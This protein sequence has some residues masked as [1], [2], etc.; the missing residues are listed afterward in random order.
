MDEPA[1]Y[2]ALIAALLRPEAYPHPVTAISVMETHI[3][4]VLLTGRHAYKLKKPVRLSFLDFSTLER[5]HAACEKELGLNRRFAPALYEAVVPITGSLAQPRI[6]G[7]GAAL[8]FAVRMRQFPPADQLDLRLNRGLLK[9]DEFEAFGHLMARLH[10]EAATA[11]D[12]DQYG[13]PA[14][15]HAPVHDSLRE[16]STDFPDPDSRRRLQ[17]LGDWCRA[18]ESAHAILFAERRQTGRIREGHG[19]LHLA[20]LVWLDGAILPFDCIE[21]SDDL[22]W[23]DVISDAAF[24]VMDLLHRQQ[25]ALAYGF[26][27]A[28]LE[29]SGDYAGLP[30]L[31]YYLVYRALVRAKVEGIRARAL[32]GESRATHLRQARDYLD[33]AATIAF[34]RHPGLVLMHGLSGSG[35]SWISQQ[36]AAALPAIRLRSDVE[37]KRLHGLERQARTGS[38]VAGGLYSAGA[39]EDT[40]RRLQVLAQAALDGGEHVIVDACFLKAAQRRDFLALAQRMG[41]PCRILHCEAAPSVL[42]SRLAARARE[43]LDPSEADA[44]VLA[45]QQTSAEPLTG[46]DLAVTV[47]IDASAAFDAQALAA[48]IRQ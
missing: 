20:N 17:P 48:A 10:A 38:G 27:N 6:G 3:S 7:S 37:R 28:Y 36:L 14:H 33:L 29:A 9:G 34:D 19:D 1:S 5:R 25:P 4:W 16:L 21:F 44:A 26:L 43:G 32:G 2:P 39:S 46:D 31:P 13:T 24:L 11:G 35:K 18:Q 47:R 22:R 8:E 12:G 23:N 30:L 42:E 45:H 41:L 15:V 40:Y